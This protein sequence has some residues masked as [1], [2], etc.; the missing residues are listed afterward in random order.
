MNEL[1][2]VFLSIPIL[3][4]F[5]KIFNVIISCLDWQLINKWTSTLICAGLVTFNTNW[6]ICV[7][8]NAIEVNISISLNSFRTI[9]S[10][11][12]EFNFLTSLLVCFSIAIS[13]LSLTFLLLP[14]VQSFYLLPLLSSFFFSFFCLSSSIFSSLNGSVSS[15]FK[16]WLI[17]LSLF[18]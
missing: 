11:Y 9:L 3:R 16:N 5:V 13:T 6:W 8:F 4:R 14:L 17:N 7:F 15:I 1:S 12:I 10:S 18:L 2:R